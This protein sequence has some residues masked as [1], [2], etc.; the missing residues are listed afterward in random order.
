M[1][2]NYDFQNRRSLVRGRRI[3][4]DASTQEANAAL[5]RLVRRDTG[6]DYRQ[7]LER[8]A[9]DSGIETPST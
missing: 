5:R 7:M 8:L 1:G 2:R 4:V 6:E 3:G 9:K